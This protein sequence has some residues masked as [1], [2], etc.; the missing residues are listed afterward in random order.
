[1]ESTQK[2]AATATPGRL[3]GRVAL[4]TGAAQGIG[5]ALAIRLAQDG[6]DVVIAAHR[7]PPDDTEVAV[8][9]AGVES[10]VHHVDVAL[11]EEVADL[12][13]AVTERFGRVDVLVNNAG[14]YPMQGFLEMTYEQWRE[15]FQINA[16]SV[17]HTCRAFV[18]GMVER[19]WGR[20]INV[21]S[22]SFMEGMANYTHYNAAK[23]AIVG[24]TRSLAIEVG[25]A[26]VTANVLAPGLVRT[27]TTDSGPQADGMFEGF[28]AEQ[29]IKRTETPE[30]LAGAVSWLASEDA[31]FVTGQTIVVDGGWHFN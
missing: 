11:E 23:A 6:A 10:L 22:T 5:Q 13:T 31:S 15:M 12:A 17:F 19:R 20:V 2:S 29:A 1:M 24:F 4:V 9:A 27:P 18:P 28:L 7:T 14:S 8:K 16:D 26:E 30:D 21:S 25:P 3:E